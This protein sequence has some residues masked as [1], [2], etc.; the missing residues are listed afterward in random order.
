M[1]YILDALR[2]S[3]QDRADDAIPV[4]HTAPRVAPGRRPLWRRIGLGVLIAASAALAA[5]QAGPR[6]LTEA[7]MALQ[8][9]PSGDPGS[10][11]AGKAS[12]DPPA[13]E[14]GSRG[15]KE[16]SAPEPADARAADAPAPQAEARDA[17]SPARARLGGL[18]LN[19]V[20][21]SEV[22]ERRFV[23]IDQRIVRESE[24]AA[25]GVVVKRI[26]PG[27]AIVQVGGEEIL[28][29]PE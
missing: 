2:K 24:A 20:S 4:L 16:R 22:P 29:R 14:A 11:P 12:T 23:M 17:G 15:V 7:R 3:E 6:L 9:T 5:W 21:Y 25:D 27:G 18:S 1:S 26:V 10:E 19:V 13:A 28:L 8:A